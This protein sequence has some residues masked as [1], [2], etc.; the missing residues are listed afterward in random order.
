MVCLTCGSLEADTQS[1]CAQ[2]SSF[3]GYAAEGRGYLP[4]LL[5]LQQGLKD[6]TI[7]AEQGEDRLVR[8]DEVLA[9]TLQ[10]MDELGA[11]ITSLPLDEVQSGTVGGFLHP[12][13]DSLSQLREVA[14]NLSLDGNWSEAEWNSLK[15]AQARLLQ[16]NQGVAYLYQ[17]LG[18]LAARQGHAWPPS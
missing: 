15:A 17:F 18:D 13:R 1:Q 16:A 14:A 4:Q 8:L 3:L 11:Q 12:V 5:H 2:C 10:Q 9:T 7:T 6:L